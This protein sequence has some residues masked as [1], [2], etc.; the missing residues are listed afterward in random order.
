MAR[1]NL[2]IKPKF[3]PDDISDI[4]YERDR[5]R[6]VSLYVMRKAEYKQLYLAH[7]SWLLDERE[8]LQSEL[9]HARLKL[10]KAERNLEIFSNYGGRR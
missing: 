2:H 5:L 7:V 9:T 6:K 1:L 10:Q 8:R 4:R 3:E